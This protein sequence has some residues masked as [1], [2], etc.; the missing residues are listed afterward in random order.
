MGQKLKN[1]HN[2]FN[3][4]CGVAPFLVTQK[5]GVAPFIITR[6]RRA[7]QFLGIQ[8]AGLINSFDRYIT[9]S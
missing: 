7:A 9:K 6:K 3:P 1:S 8:N 5:H 2:S 4:K